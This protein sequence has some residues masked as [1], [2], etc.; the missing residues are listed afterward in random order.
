MVYHTVSRKQARLA[1]NGAIV[2][3]KLINGVFVIYGKDN[4]CY[5]KIQARLGEIV[6]LTFGGL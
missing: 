6:N 5:C 3:V 4:W 1:I 2:I